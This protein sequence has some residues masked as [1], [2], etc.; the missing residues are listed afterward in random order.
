MAVIAIGSRPE[1]SNVT[2]FFELRS[3]RGKRCVLGIHILGGVGREGQRFL[4]C[5]QYELI[6]TTSDTQPPLKKEKST[7]SIK[8]EIIFT[9]ILQ[10][11]NLQTKH[12][13]TQNL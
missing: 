5:D 1:A 7:Q 9:R 2:K 11:K 12:F 8:Q 3:H 10:T 4:K 13:S 6:L